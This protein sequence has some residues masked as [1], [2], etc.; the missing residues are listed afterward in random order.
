MA[1]PPAAAAPGPPAVKKS[2]TDLV[3]QWLNKIYIAHSV[4]DSQVSNVTIEK[5][6]SITDLTAWLED[7]Q[8]SVPMALLTAEHRPSNVLVLSD[9]SVQELFSIGTGVTP[10]TDA[11][12]EL[13][14][15]KKSKQKKAKRSGKL[16]KKNAQKAG[17]TPHDGRSDEES[18]EEADELE[19]AGGS[20][21]GLLIVDTQKKIARFVDSAI[22]TRKTAAN[23]LKITKMGEAGTAAGKVLRGIEALLVDGDGGKGVYVSGQRGF[24]ATTL[25]HTPQQ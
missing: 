24:E 17:A 14:Q 8:I 2:R 5:F 1:A 19:A 16:K 10:T 6:F 7:T 13:K 18:D 9:P 20:H 25:K 12:P 11:A 23:K 21:W 3:G 15:L 22:G 4:E